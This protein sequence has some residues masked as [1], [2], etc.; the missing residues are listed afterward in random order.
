[1]I[2]QTTKKRV[3]TVEIEVFGKKSRVTKE[4]L[5]RRPSSYLDGIILH[6]QQ[7][8]AKKKKFKF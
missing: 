1:M 3:K 4:Y 2:S 6:N 8:E 7:R 5:N